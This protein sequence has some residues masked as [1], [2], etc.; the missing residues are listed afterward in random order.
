MTE[1]MPKVA[2]SVWDTLSLAEKALQWAHHEADILNV[3][4]VG[5]NGGARVME[6]LKSAGVPRPANW[7][8]AA[9][10]WCL[11]KA[12]MSKAN[13]PINPASA[14]NWVEWGR[15][16]GHIIKAPKR[17]CLFAWCNREKWKGHIGFVVKGFT[18]GGIG[19]I[20]TLEGNASPQSGTRNGDGFYRK[21]RIVTKNFTFIEVL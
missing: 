6:Y 17:G 9:V 20:E 14:C 7:C 3:R 2:E 13:M 19:Y 1:R 5:D 18:I 10:T 16:F 12:G 21:R 15:K 8:A 4:E 11:R